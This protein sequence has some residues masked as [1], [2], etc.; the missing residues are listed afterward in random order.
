[1]FFK[2]RFHLKYLVSKQIINLFVSLLFLERKKMQSI[3]YYSSTR[4][5]P[6]KKNCMSVLLLRQHKSGKILYLLYADLK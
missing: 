6:L 3:P 1:M 2:T 4:C 5:N